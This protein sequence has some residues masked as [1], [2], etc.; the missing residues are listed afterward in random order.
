LAPHAVRHERGEEEDEEHLAD[1]RRLEA[2]GPELDPPLR[3]AHVVPD[4][5]HEKQER[6]GHHV[7]SL[8]VAAVELRADRHRG[9]GDDRAGCDVD[10]LA[11]DEVVRVAGHV[12]PGHRGQDPDAV[13]DHACDGGDQEVVEV[14][15]VGA[16]L[17]ADVRPCRAGFASEGGHQSEL[18][19][20]AL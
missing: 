20:T 18:F 13:R 2:E 14:A 6:D 17:G 19:T 4:H 5:E 8:R 7:Q 10:L 11:R 3:P 9:R 12:V 1:L 16:D 15:E